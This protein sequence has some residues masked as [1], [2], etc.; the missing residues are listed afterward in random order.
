MR[1]TILG[2]GSSGGVPRVGQGWGACDPA[3]PRNRRQRCSILVEKFTGD[4]CTRLLVDM[5]PDLRAQLLEHDVQRLD[6]IALSHAHADHLHGIDDVR[7]LVIAARHRIPLYMDAVTANEVRTK[8]GYILETPPGSSYPPLLN[9]HRIEPGIFLAV[10]GPG[11]PIEALPVLFRH[12]DID[13]LGFRFGDTLYSPDLNA[14]P[15]ASEAALGGLDLWI[16]DALR[17]TPHPSHI[18]VTEALDLIARYRP[19]RAIL[20][21]LHTDLDYHTLARSLP[22]GVIPAHDGMIVGLD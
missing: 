18:S 7:P 1:I 22:P 2:C 8:F 14:V 11:G 12:G 21:N 10:E 15:A 3:E 5:S 6:A 16:I 13:A 20:T 19:K 4:T 9:D 17:Y